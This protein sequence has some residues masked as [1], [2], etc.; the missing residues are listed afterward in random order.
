MR[1]CKKCEW[2]FPDDMREC[3]YCGHPVEPEDKKQKRRFNLRWHPNAF[4]A[5]V[6]QPPSGLAPSPTPPKKHSHLVI[7]VSTITVMLLLAGT[8]IGFVWADTHLRPASPHPSP[9]VPIDQPLIV[10]PS[11]LDFGQ[12]EVGRKSVLSVIIK[13]S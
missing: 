7:L 8:L 13:K 11:L 4:T 5:G 3:P 12:V 10:N 2:E 1:T 9:T 6:K